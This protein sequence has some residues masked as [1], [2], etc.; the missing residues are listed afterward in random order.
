MTRKRQLPAVTTT[1][2]FEAIRKTETVQLRLS[3]S[4]KE[5]I[6]KA[7]TKSGRTVTEYLLECHRL[8]AAKIK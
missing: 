3:A 6:R 1:E 5:A 4:E 2:I 7:A 8:V